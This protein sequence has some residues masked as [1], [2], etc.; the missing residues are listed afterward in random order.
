MPQTYTSGNSHHPP[1]RQ[2]CCVWSMAGPSTWEAVST[3]ACLT[4]RVPTVPTT[5]FPSP[6]HTSSL[7]C[8]ASWLLICALSR[9]ASSYK[10]LL[11]LTHLSNFILL[12]LLFIYNFS[13][14]LLLFV[15][16]LLLFVT[17]PYLFIAPS[18][19]PPSPSKLPPPT[20]PF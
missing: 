17:L 6:L 8:L 18:L 2:A 20:P 11:W 4:G 9:L 3:T 10:S 16:F 5:T 1:H 7:S 12:S 13:I 15:V 14:T 19:Y